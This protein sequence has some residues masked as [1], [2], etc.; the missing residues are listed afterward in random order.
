[1]GAS[2]ADTKPAADIQA[3]SKVTAP[4]AAPAVD[5]GVGLQDGTAAPRGD[6][7]G[8]YFV[9][10]TKSATSAAP[11]DPLAADPKSA[12]PILTPKFNIPISDPEL[13]RAAQTFFGKVLYFPDRLSTTWLQSL[14]QQK[15]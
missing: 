15:R 14:S 11:P 12:A 6:F 2:F 7:R 5:Q 4:A 10:T 9:Q 1:M 13:N 3:L 8:T